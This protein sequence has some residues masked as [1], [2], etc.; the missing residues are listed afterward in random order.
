MFR[1]SAAQHAVS[2][3]SSPHLRRDLAVE[4]GHRSYPVASCSSPR[5]ARRTYVR[6]HCLPYD[7]MIDVNACGVGSLRFA[8]PGRCS[9]TN[10]A[11][12]TAECQVK[13]CSIASRVPLRPVVTASPTRDLK[14]SGS[15]L[16]VL[17]KIG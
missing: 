17:A 9:V 4:Q 14:E 15:C 6:I 8:D 16:P 3:C 13:P 10:A 5:V 7:H 11:A 2:S 12:D 1:L